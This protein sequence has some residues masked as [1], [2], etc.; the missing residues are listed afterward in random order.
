MSGGAALPLITLA[1]LASVEMLNQ[2]QKEREAEE[3]GKRGL[4]E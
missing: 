2:G 1:G 4:P 3:Y